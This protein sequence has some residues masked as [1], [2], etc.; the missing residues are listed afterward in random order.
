M[1]RSYSNLSY[2]EN[3]VIELHHSISVCF[4]QVYSTLNEVLQEQFGHVLVHLGLRV[5]VSPLH[6]LLQPGEDAGVGVELLHQQAHGDA[7]LLGRRGDGLVGV[8]LPDEL[9]HVR[10]ATQLVA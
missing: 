10:H 9:R 4:G 1:I 6:G 8:R 7:G 2:S 5:H 3:G